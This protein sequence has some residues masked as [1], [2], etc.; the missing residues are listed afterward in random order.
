M[1]N[2][3]TLKY[4]KF[5]LLLL[6]NIIEQFENIVFHLKM[7]ACTAALHWKIF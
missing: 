7:A 4:S 3:G 6:L 2:G 5:N 1:I